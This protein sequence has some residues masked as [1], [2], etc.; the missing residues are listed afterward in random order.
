MTISVRK[1]SLNEQ[2]SH[3]LNELQSEIR[4]LELK[5]L[6]LKLFDFGHVKQVKDEEKE[7]TIKF[8]LEQLSSEIQSRYLI[9]H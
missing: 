4:E 7:A 8:I 3:T 5:E 2:Q 1:Q 6:Q 9:A